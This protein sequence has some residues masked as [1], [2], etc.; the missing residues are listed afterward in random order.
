MQATTVPSILAMLELLVCE[1]TVIIASFAL[2]SLICSMS[3]ISMPSMSNMF[4]VDV[5][6]TVPL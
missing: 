3:V 4:A 1:S 6:A 2:R 5:F